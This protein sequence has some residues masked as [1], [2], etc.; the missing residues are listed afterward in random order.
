[1]AGT[2]CSSPAPRPRTRSGCDR[3]P[4]LA[5]RP[6]PGTEGGA[7]PV[8]VARQPVHRVLRGGQTEESPDRRRTADRAVRRAG[9]ARRELEPRQRDPVRAIGRRHRPAARVERRRD[10]DRRHDARS[11]DRRNEPPVAALSARWPSFPLH[12]HRRAPAVPPS[13]PAVISVGSLDPADAAVTLSA[14]R[15]VG[16]IRL[17]PSVVRARRDADG[18]AV[19][20]STRVSCRAMP[21]RWP[22]TSAARAAATSSASASENGTLVYAPAAASLAPQQLTWFDRAGHA[23]GT[24]GEPA[25]VPQPRAVARRTPRRRLAGEPEARKTA[26]SGSSISPARHPVPPDVRSR[27]R[28]GRR[29]V[30]RWHAHRLRGRAGGR[31]LAAPAGD[32]RKPPMNRC[33]KALALVEPTDWSADGRFIAYH[34]RRPVRGLGCLGPAVVRR[35][36]TVPRSRRRRSPK[37]SARVLSRWPMDRLSTERNG[38]AQ[39]LRPAVSR[40]RAAKFQVSRNGGSQSDVASGRQGTVL[41]RADGTMM[42]VPIEAT[43]HFDA[44]VPQRPVRTDVVR[45]GVGRQY[46]V[47]KDGKRFL[48][49]APDTRRC[50]PPHAAD[51]GRQ[52][53]GAAF[54]SNRAAYCAFSN[55]TSCRRIRHGDEVIRRGEHLR[56]HRPALRRSLPR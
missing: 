22:S 3:S 51:G 5:A 54:R 30:A 8:L 12:R 31:G 42:A 55:F 26:T 13:K 23:L 34:Q 20:S 11:G 17:R 37:R 15:V 36:Q 24:L 50:E 47:T 53:V 43:R 10:A 28:C 46:A 7:F 32:Q 48:I 41:P 16:V 27:Q 44:G 19:R 45:S 18:A 38:A 9:R 40:R 6:I 49:N 25:P 21:F 56:R 1:M 2:S 4:A 29:L 14:G 35:S 33:S 39:C 52:L